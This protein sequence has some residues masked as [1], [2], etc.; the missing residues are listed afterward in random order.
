MAKAMAATKAKAKQI[1]TTIDEG[2]VGFPIAI[3]ISI[4]TA[5]L[6]E[7]IKCFIPSNPEQVKKYVTARYSAEEAGEFYKGYS[8]RL[9]KTMMN[10]A[11]VAAANLRPRIRLED[12]AAMEIAIKTLDDIRQGDPVA[13]TSVIDEYYDS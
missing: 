7:I 8:S 4:V 2:K 11:K 1:A 9:V 6:P 5:L 10:R 12:G 3:I 13:M